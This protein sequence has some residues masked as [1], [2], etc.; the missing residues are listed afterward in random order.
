MEIEVP[1]MSV[2]LEKIDNGFRVDNR[3][4]GRS[5][6]GKSSVDR[7]STR[8]FIFS[9]TVEDEFCNFTKE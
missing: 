3:R 1:R 7:R 5:N 9:N 8:I 2:D 6:G 4:T